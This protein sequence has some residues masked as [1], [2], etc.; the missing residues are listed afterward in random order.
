V[1]TPC[2]Q[3]C[4]SGARCCAAPLLQLLAW[5][6]LPSLVRLLAAGWRGGPPHACLSV[7]CSSCRG[8]GARVSAQKLLLLLLDVQRQL[9]RSWRCQQYRVGV[10][11]A[12][13]RGVGIVSPRLSPVAQVISETR[14]RKV[15]W[16]EM[17]RQVGCVGVKLWANIPPG[18]W[19]YLQARNCVQ[20][21]ARRAFAPFTATGARSS[22]VAHTQRQPLLVQH[23]RD[24]GVGVVHDCCTAGCLPIWWNRQAPAGGTNQRAPPTCC[25]SR[26]ARNE[27]CGRVCVAPPAPACAH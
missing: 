1:L 4:G 19:S 20:L 6:M 9:G 21:R 23:V 18:C 13:E 10:L 2:L 26:R 22:R 3:P 25:E 8:A 7:V 5:C 17:R 16:V 11:R 27:C 14:V 15:C 12:G 24:G